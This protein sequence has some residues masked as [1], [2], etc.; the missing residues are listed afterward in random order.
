HDLRAPLRTV[1]GFTQALLDDFDGKLPQG[2]QDH[3][4]RVQRAALRMSKLIDALLELSR[5]SRADLN[6]QPFDFSKMARS[7]ANEL[8]ES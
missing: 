8:A 2:A 5:T 1:R 7:V 3:V 4:N 6:R